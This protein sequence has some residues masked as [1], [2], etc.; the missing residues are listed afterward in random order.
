M[1]LS[2]YGVYLCVHSY[3][4]VSASSEAIKKYSYYKIDI[5]LKKFQTTLE[6]EWRWRGMAK[7]LGISKDVWFEVFTEYFP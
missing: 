2:G 7:R 6:V 5:P 4:L 3:C 1:A